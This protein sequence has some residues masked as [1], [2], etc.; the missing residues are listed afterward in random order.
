[1]CFC[2]VCMAVIDSRI[3]DSSETETRPWDFGTF[4]ELP[5]ADS[6]SRKNA[7]MWCYKRKT[8]FTVFWVSGRNKDLNI[9]IPWAIQIVP[10]HTSVSLRKQGNLLWTLWLNS[11]ILLHLLS[12]CKSFWINA[13]S[14]F[15]CLFHPLSKQ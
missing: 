6:D 3:T 13:K 11:L 10:S 5:T 9:I 4:S 14:I 8:Y 1:M 12:L 2:V 15:L 7:V